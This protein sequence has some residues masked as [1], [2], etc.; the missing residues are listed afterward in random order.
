MIALSAPIVDQRE[1]D[2]KQ[3][4]PEKNADEA[5]RDDTSEN[6]EQHED[7]RQVAASTD[8]ERFEHVIDTAHH[9]NA[10]HQ[11]KGGPAG[12]ALTV[13]PKRRGPPNERRTDG[14]GR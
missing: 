5:E 1:A 3:R 8:D 14:Q 13:Q 6:A 2:R 10:P 9:E 7:E 12:M 4:R 11:Q